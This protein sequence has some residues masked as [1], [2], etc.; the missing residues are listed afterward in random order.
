[1]VSTVAGVVV[2]TVAAQ[3]LGLPLGPVVDRDGGPTGT[4]AEQAVVDFGRGTLH[5]RA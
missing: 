2:D 4:V 3:R 1:M 5:L